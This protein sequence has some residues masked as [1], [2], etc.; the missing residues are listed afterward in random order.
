[1]YIGLF[2]LVCVSLLSLFFLKRMDKIT[3]IQ[4][5]QAV[6]E[7]ALVFVENLD[8]EYLSENF[9]SS[10]RIWIDLVHTSGLSRMD[11]SIHQLMGR[12]RNNETIHDFLL[13]NGFSLSMHLV[14]KDQLTHMMYLS[15]GDQFNDHEF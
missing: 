15:Y 8:Y 5:I 10:N 14:G 2:A 6:P 9:F 1:M 11:S 12:L 3:P 4:V 7:D 13:K